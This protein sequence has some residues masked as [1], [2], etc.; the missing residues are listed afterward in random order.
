M[1][2]P[3]DLAGIGIGPFNLSLAALL[4]PVAG[5]CARFF[6]RKSTFSWH[7]GQLLPAT[8]LQ[9]SFLKDLVT[10]VDPTSRHSF[11]AYLVEKGRFYEFVHADQAAVSRAEFADY[12]GWVAGRL[13]SLRFAAS[14][15][16]ID[17]ESGVFRLRG[18]F[19]QALA[20]NLALATG[21][22]PAL[23]AWAEALVG[24][25][26]FH[27]SRLLHE[28]PDVTGL[29]VAIVGGGQ[30]G[31]EAF[32]SLARDLFGRAR[33]LTWISRRMAFAPLD[34]THLT[35]EWFTPGY[36]Q[37]FHALPPERR[38]RHLRDQRLASDGISPSTLAEIYQLLYER[39]HL[40]LDGERFRLLPAREAQAADLDRR[41]YTLAL[42]NRFD[43][44]RESACADLVVMATGFAWRLPDCL[45]P[46]SDRI[47]TDAT[48]AVPLD[49]RFRLVWDAPSGARI[50][51]LNGGLHSHGIAEPQLSLMAWRSAVIAN[52]LAGF[53]YYRLADPRP[54]IAWST[55]ISAGRVTMASAGAG[56]L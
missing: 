24:P 3:L 31:A 37:A 19:G 5:L 11:L 18:S 12:L 41:Q 34:E 21:R 15:D 22:E 39:R 51:L 9:T 25:R 32:L 13:A 40:A 27:V 55:A 29:R 33:S 7:G 2:E 45:A 43:G 49:E 35:N 47:A 54:L 10:P 16:A 42:A 28:R 56:H 44:G 50:Y 17:L 6:E 20:R 38:L 14:V 8:R 46:L 53:A 30:S 36:V 4:E 52:D 48:G 1:S 26:F 23:P